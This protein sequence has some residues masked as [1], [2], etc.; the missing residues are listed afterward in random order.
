MLPLC[1]FTDI[2]ILYYHLDVHSI[3]LNMFS[4]KEETETERQRAVREK[5]VGRK[6]RGGEG[7]LMEKE[8]RR[9]E[10]ALRPQSHGFEYLLSNP[11]FLWPCVNNLLIFQNVSFHYLQ[12]PIYISV[13]MYR[14]L[15]DH[16]FY[17]ELTI[18]CQHMNFLS[19]FLHLK[20]DN[21]NIIYLFIF[22]S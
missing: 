13:T 16:Y 11:V 15:A 3:P 1:I 4:L 5:E 9:Q 19:K 2:Q 17:L 14:E 6:R 10:G 20:K 12:T 7:I 22:L 21:D 18:C 8:L